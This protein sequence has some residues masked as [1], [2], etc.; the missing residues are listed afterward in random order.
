MET[1][2]AINAGLAILS[3]AL[4]F[5]AKIRGQA[6]EN[7]DAILAAAQTTTSANDAFY[8]TLMANLMAPVPTVPAAASIVK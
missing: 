4:D 1:T 6:G 5:I 3:A 7:D 2:V 8:A